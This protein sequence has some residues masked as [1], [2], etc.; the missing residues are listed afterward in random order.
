MTS[1]WLLDEIRPTALFSPAGSRNEIEDAE[2]TGSIHIKANGGGPEAVLG[3]DKLDWILGNLRK[4][5]H[6]EFIRIGTKM[7]AV[8]P[9][10]ITPQF[11][12]MLK[13]YSRSWMKFSLSPLQLGPGRSQKASGR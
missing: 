8:L 3:E 10:R 2:V 12:R 9:Q 7:P 11:C 1:F 13:K 6:L 4:I 5:P